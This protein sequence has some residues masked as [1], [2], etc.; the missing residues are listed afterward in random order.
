[1][2]A[3]LDMRLVALERRVQ[4]VQPRPSGITF[5]AFAAAM[6][7]ALANV[8]THEVGALARPWLNAMQHDELRVLVG[9][10]D[11]KIAARAAT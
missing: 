6:A 10:I 1:M 4:A 3:S 2:A 8:P 11:K 7:S 9:A 5:E